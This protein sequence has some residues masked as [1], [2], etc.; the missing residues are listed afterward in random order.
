MGAGVDFT[1]DPRRVFYF[2]PMSTDESL[3]HPV[4]NAAMIKR[5]QAL[6]GNAVPL[7]GKMK[8]AQMVRHCQIPIQAA[9]GQVKIKRSLF[10]KLFGRI[11]K[12]KLFDEKPFPKSLPTDKHFVVKT[13]PAFAADREKLN[14]LIRH[15]ASPGKPGLASDPHPFFGPLTA[16]ETEALQR[17]HLDHHLRQFGA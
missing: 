3:Y 7:W 14:A 15:F 17:K 6:S 4:A 12:R 9:F 13:D 11:A 16:D 5:L 2:M 10:G 8:V 1:R